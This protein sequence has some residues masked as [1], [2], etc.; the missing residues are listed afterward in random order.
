MSPGVL[1]HSIHSASL[2]VLVNAIIKMITTAH[3]CVYE[4]RL[5][6]A[7]HQQTAIGNKVLRF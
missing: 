6:G 3:D 1:V 5:Q 7:Y 2:G 4:Y